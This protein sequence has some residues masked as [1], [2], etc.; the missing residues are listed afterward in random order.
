MNRDEFNL[1]IIPQISSRWKYIASDPIVLDDW[2]RGLS[3]YSVTDV[4]NSI[5]EMITKTERPSLPKLLSIL[6]ANCKSEWA[7]PARRY[8]SD[9]D[10]VAAFY[11][12]VYP[13]AANLST[14]QVLH[15]V[16]QQ[17]FA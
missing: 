8:D 3:K 10:E 17:N 11:K 14:Q 6:K 9:A 12:K 13:Y 7:T 4:I 15:W 2:R 16:D 5:E 1:K